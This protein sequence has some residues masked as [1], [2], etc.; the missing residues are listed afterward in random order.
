MRAELDRSSFEATVLP[1][2]NFSGPLSRVHCALPPPHPRHR[3]LHTASAWGGSLPSQV[4]LTPP[5]RG[6]AASGQALAPR[7]PVC[8]EQTCTLPPSPAGASLRE[9]K[10][11]YS[12]LRH[13]TFDGADLSSASFVE[14]DLSHASF[15]GA[16]GVST[17]RFDRVLGMNTVKGLD[18]KTLAAALLL[19]G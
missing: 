1:H 5:G 9:A 13:T 4:P 3:P 12:S 15:F 8:V 19:Q 7:C 11:E 16:T 17:A 18:R 10:L 14:S 6:D 2:A